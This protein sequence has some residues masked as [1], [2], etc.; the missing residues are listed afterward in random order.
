MIPRTMWCRHETSYDLA[1][2]RDFLRWYYVLC[3]ADTRLLTMIPRIMW[4]RHEI[5]YDL[6]PTRDFLRWYHVL[7][8]ADTRLLTMIGLPRTVWCRHETSYNL[9]PTRD[10]LRF[11][12][13]TRLLTLI[14]HS[15][16]RRHETSVRKIAPLMLFYLLLAHKPAV[17]QS[18]HIHEVSRS[19]T[20][21]HHSR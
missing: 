7:C 12:A 19:H 21:T 9:A 2:T 20:T 10:F 16:W 15:V 13:D 4:C 11:G 6:A 5:S 17:E 14:P 3:G 1:P 8:G 18:L